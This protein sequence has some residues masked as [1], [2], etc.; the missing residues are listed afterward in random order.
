M[1]TAPTPVLAAGDNV[2]DKTVC[3]A[4]GHFE[5]TLAVAVHEVHVNVSAFKRG[6]ERR[7]DEVCWAQGPLAEAVQWLMQD[8][9]QL[10]SQLEVL[11]R[12]VEGLTGRG[13]DRSALEERDSRGRIPMTSSQGTVNRSQGSPSTTVPSG[14]SESGFSDLGSGASSST[15]AHLSS[16]EPMGNSS[17]ANGHKVV[18]KMEEKNVDAVLE[19]GNDK[20]QVSGQAAEKHKPHLPVSAMTRTSPES[21][22]GPRRASEELKSAGHSLEDVTSPKAIPDYL[23]KSEDSSFGKPHLPCTAMTKTDSPTSPKP[24]AQSPALAQ[25]SPALTPKYPTYPIADVT[26]PKTALVALFSPTP[27]LKRET[28]V[29]MRTFTLPG[30]LQGPAESS[31]GQHQEVRSPVSSHGAQQEHP[32]PVSLAPPYAP[33]SALT[34][35]SPEV[36]TA[37]APT[38][39]PATPSWAPAAPYQSSAAQTQSPAATPSPAPKTPSQSVFEETTPKASGEFPF[40]RSERDKF[41][42]PNK[43]GGLDKFGG[44]GE[45]KLQRS[46]TLPR[47]LGMQGK[48]SLFE[49]LAYE[50]DRSK[51]AGSK[52]RLQ[53]TQSFN[54]ASNIKAM[55]LEWC[56]SKTIGYQNIDIQNFSSS[57]CDGMTFAALVH[58]FFPLVFDYNTL[59]P[60]N[61]KHNF[62]M[63]FTTAEEQAD[64][65][66]L[67]EVEDMMAMGSKP[68]P[69]CI[70]T[71]VQSL[72]NHLKK[73]E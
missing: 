53:R 39:S 52:P 66:R 58:S 34:K 5:S 26:T 6:V 10:R 67:I 56:R 32:T 8:N 27:A 35:T 20:E 50:C 9:L 2:C 36:P 57:W 15:S 28:P 59:N 3:E 44:G 24:P 61:R 43:L 71:Y 68:D 70:F 37:P 49:S 7:V 4:L 51:A 23:Y 40:K 13:V 48:R 73:F 63:A 64:C 41:D 19:N 47:N 16:R 69:K 25:K 14:L 29:P 45:R 55:L 18:D 22:T 33:V 12:L 11:A 17:M 38:Q 54:S 21:P 31:S 60:A 72:Y 46:Q 1:D 65:V 62:E 42:S 30:L